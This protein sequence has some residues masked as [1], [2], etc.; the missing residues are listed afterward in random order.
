M[1]RAKKS[2]AGRPS[3]PLRPVVVL[4]GEA[5]QPG[6]YMGPGCRFEVLSVAHPRRYQVSDLYRGQLMEIAQKREGFQAV[7]RTIT[8][9]FADQFTQLSKQGD[10][11]WSRL[12]KDMGLPPGIRH[13]MLNDGSVE[14]V[15]EADSSTKR[16]E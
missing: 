7:L 11:V 14:E 5:T 9:H 13:T 2:V 15:L 16:K 4:A 1:K 6:L 8:G 3:G 10:A 12:E